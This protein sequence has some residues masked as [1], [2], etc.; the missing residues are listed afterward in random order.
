[1]F[2]SVSI[3]FTSVSPG[4]TENLNNLF[5]QHVFIFSSRICSWGSSNSPSNR[6]KL[7][8]LY[9]RYFDKRIQKRH[10]QVRKT[11]LFSKRRYQSLMIVRVLRKEIQNVI[12]FTKH[13]FHQMLMVETIKMNRYSY[14]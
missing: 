8:F 3:V 14:F 13:L 7:R 6:T 2:T 9:L 10:K 11:I 4:D 5:L 1:M 12:N